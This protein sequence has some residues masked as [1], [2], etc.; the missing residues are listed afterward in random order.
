MSGEGW[1]GG[2]GNAGIRVAGYMAARKGCAG[3]S[4]RNAGEEWAIRNPWGIPRVQD[5]PIRDKLSA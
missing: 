1:G 4:Q 3:T 2:A 5:G